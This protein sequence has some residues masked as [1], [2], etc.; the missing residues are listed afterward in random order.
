ME[1]AENTHAVILALSALNPRHGVVAELLSIL[2]PEDAYTL[3]RLLASLRFHTGEMRGP[4]GIESELTAAVG[5]DGAS[6]VLAL[7]DAKPLDF[8]PFREIFKYVQMARCYTFARKFGPDEA[9]KRLGLDRNFVHS[10]RMMV[11]RKLNAV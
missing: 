10:K 9:A 3:L 2:P 4:H 8:P 1:R 5:A 7:A 11:H 6:R